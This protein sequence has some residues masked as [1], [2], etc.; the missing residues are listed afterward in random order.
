MLSPSMPSASSSLPSNA[1]PEGTACNQAV[2]RWALQTHL[3][4]ADRDPELIPY[5]EARARETVGAYENDAMR[6]TIAADGTRLTIAAAIKPEIRTASDK[7]MPP[8]IPPSAMGLLP[9]DKD[10]YIVLEGGLKGARGFFTRDERG[11]VVGIDVGGRLFN[12]VPA[13]SNSG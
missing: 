10:E 8:D 1:G 12:R 5:D 11:A 13:A 4:V 3:G 7:E 6:A 2:V 9:G